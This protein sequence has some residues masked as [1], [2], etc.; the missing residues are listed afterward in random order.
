MRSVSWERKSSG[1][2]PSPGQTI[3]DEPQ[4]EG[5]SWIRDRYF[6][7]NLSKEPFVQRCRVITA[8]TT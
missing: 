2:Y 7:R 1:A 8:L 5:S 6:Y 4:L 3:A